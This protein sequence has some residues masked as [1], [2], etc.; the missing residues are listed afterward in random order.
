M[1]VPELTDKVEHQGEMVL[2]GNLGRQESGASLEQSDLQG[3]QELVEVLVQKDLR[4][5]VE[6]KGVWDQRVKVETLAVRVIKEIEA[7]QE[8][9]ENVEKMVQ[10]AL[11]YVDM[12][13]PHAH[14]WCIIVILMF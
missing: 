2:Q 8:H 4:V 10:E 13:I 7:T 9:Q 14:R 12:L 6:K 1:V 3:F 5:Q 11:Q